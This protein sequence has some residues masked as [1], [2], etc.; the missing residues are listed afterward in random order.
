[1][2]K[3]TE[4]PN[5]EKQLHKTLALRKKD[6]WALAINA[7]RVRRSQSWRH[8]S[9]F[10]WANTTLKKILQFLKYGLTKYDAEKTVKT[11]K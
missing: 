3:Y 9:A 8:L 6:R 7:G 1:M 2:D 11:V 5:Y 10:P 4:G